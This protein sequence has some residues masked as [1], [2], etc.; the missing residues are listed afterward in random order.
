MNSRRSDVAG[1]IRSIKPEILDDEVATDLSDAAWRLWVSS[2]L[3][4]DDH[5]RFR[6]APRYL[7]AEVWQDTRR[8]DAAAAALD[9][10][11]RVRL[12]R[13][14][15][16][17]GQ[18]YA[19]IK[20]SGWKKHQRIDHPGAPRVPVPEPGDYLDAEDRHRQGR[21]PSAATEPAEKPRAITNDPADFCAVPRKP[22]DD[23]PRPSETLAPRARAL[24]L[25][26]PI[27]D[28]RSPTSD[29][30]VD[31]RNQVD[32]PTGPSTP[33]A[34]TSATD[35]TGTSLPLL[36]IG[37]PTAKAAKAT[38]RK[39]ATPLLERD[40]LTPAEQVVHDAIAEDADLAR[41]CRTVPTLARDLVRAAPSVDLVR[42]VHAL[43]AWLRAN[44]ARAKVNGNAFLVRCIGRKQ[45]EA[46][47]RASVAPAAPAVVDRLPPA[48]PRAPPAVEAERE[49]LRAARAAGETPNVSEVI[50]RVGRAAQPRGGSYP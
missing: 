31:R 30:E 9:E 6:A 17:E 34:T 40:D 20:P 39:P 23:H 15:D 4:A 8:I 12:V 10:L 37:P 29:Q 44:P 7:A 3:L 14:Y 33:S 50:A 35:D 26:S 36:P 32:G 11:A 45:L 47:D 1:R 38:K 27:S 41:I 5:G 19:E 24:D 25:R 18:A 22:S 43:G 48:P 46:A 28:L 2:W 21:R 49:R 16:V 13:R 42:E